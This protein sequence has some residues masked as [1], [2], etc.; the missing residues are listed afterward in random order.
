MHTNF[1]N[2]RTLVIA[3]VGMIGA[4]HGTPPDCSPTDYIMMATANITE[5]ATC[6]TTNNPTWDSCIVALGM[7]PSCS[8]P[9]GALIDTTVTSDCTSHCTDPS[10]HGCR[11]CQ[12]VIVTEQIASFAPEVTGACSDDLSSIT[13]VTIQSVID[14]ADIS[15]IL[16]IA[17][18]SYDCGSCFMNRSVELN[19]TLGCETACTNTTAPECYDC[20][21]VLFASVMAQCSIVPWRPCTA[22][23]YETL[24]AGSI[25]D[26]AGCLTINS[27]DLETCLT[28]VNVTDT[29]ASDINFHVGDEITNEC[30]VECTSPDSDPCK[31]CI[32][33]SALVE[34][35]TLA[36]MDDIGVCGNPDDLAAIGSVNVTE[37]V[38]GENVWSLPSVAGVSAHCASCI[39]WWVPLTDDACYGICVEYG[40]P[41]ACSDCTNVGAFMALA[42]CIG[43][44]WNPNDICTEG[45]YTAIA[46]V[47]LVWLNQCIY[48]DQPDDWNACISQIANV[49]SDCADAIGMHIASANTTTCADICDGTPEAE[50]ACT[51]CQGVV[52]IQQ[53]ADQAPQEE[54]GACGN[55]TDIAVILAVNLSAVVDGLDIKSFPEIAGVSHY[56]FKCFQE[57]AAI[58]DDPDVGCGAVCGGNRTAECLDCENGVLFAAMANCNNVPWVP[59]TK[60]SE[61]DYELIADVDIL[62]M[63]ECITLDQPGDWNTCLGEALVDPDCAEQVGEEIAAFSNSTCEALCDETPDAADCRICLSVVA[64]QQISILV[65]TENGAC[66]NPDDLTA[67]I[68]ANMTAV[69]EAGSIK[70]LPDVAEV[71]YDCSSCLGDRARVILRDEGCKSLCVDDDAACMDCEKVAFVAAMAYCSNVTWVPVIECTELDYSSIGDMNITTVSDCI[72]NEHPFDW[73]L[74]LGVLDV[75]AI[76][77][78]NLNSQIAAEIPECSSVCDGG[79]TDSLACK[80]CW[81]AVA[82]RETAALSPDSEGSCGGP[83]DFAVLSALNELDLATSED[84][85]TLGDLVEGLSVFC[86]HCLDSRA[87]IIAMEEGCLAQCQDPSLPECLDCKNVVMVSAMAHCNN[88]AWEPEIEC[89]EADYDSIGRMN[90]ALFSTCKDGYETDGFYECLT[91]DSAVA[92][93]TD[94]CAVVLDTHIDARTVT[95]CEAACTED[96]AGIPCLNCQG[97]VIVQEAFEHAPLETGACGG[98]ADLAAIANVD[99]DAVIECASHKPNNAAMCVSGVARLSLKCE[100]CLLGRTH[101]AVN[102]CKNICA[103]HPASPVCMECVNGG[104]LST[105]AHCNSHPSGVAGMAGLSFLSLAA[106]LVVFLL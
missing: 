13:A 82:V 54:A 91:N 70:D 22:D 86:K 30:S 29:C 43:E 63:S 6:V 51:V 95:V 97:A 41:Q 38:E 50:S 23:D 26:L 81:G 83:D 42:D 11:I 75:G 39:S 77:A 64:V 93:V 45:D 31:I 60:C 66:G 71:S 35:A 67:I 62:W 72:T 10:S 104:M 80:T 15:S 37:I 44:T 33:A 89:T 1:F 27:G 57:R 36:P 52:V 17:E 18:V 78:F 8:T 94:V 73:Q 105:A 106:V 3:I 55:P 9:F 24:A 14:E 101:R 92:N 84:I 46:E 85:S 79:H 53:T 56:C 21:N 40:T 25:S 48:T 69:V 61:D 47:D 28:N 32:G 34:L 99:M 5:W 16:N 19:E 87:E 88:V 90:S 20:M 65:P 102:Q 7:D 58:V 98:E 2:M 103:G 49:A 12:G 96:D 76:C 74:C 68:G 59:V 4:V 100:H